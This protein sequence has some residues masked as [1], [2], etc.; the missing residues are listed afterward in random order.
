MQIEAQLQKDEELAK[1]ARF[2]NE[3]K[4]KGVHESA[5]LPNQGG[6]AGSGGVSVAGHNIRTAHGPAANLPK[7]AARHTKAAIG[8]HKQNLK[9]LKSMPSPKLGKSELETDLE[10]LEVLLKGET[11]NSKKARL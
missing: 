9:D 10:N 2:Y 11:E 8:Q 6:K 7:E 5:F 3:P 1:A 4:Q